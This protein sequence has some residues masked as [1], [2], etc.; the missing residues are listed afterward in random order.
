MPDGGARSATPERMSALSLARVVRGQVSSWAVSG[1]RP[2]WLTKGWRLQAR[3][4]CLLSLRRPVCVKV[5][6]A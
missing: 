1:R 6:V 2:R 4:L 3:F 5:V